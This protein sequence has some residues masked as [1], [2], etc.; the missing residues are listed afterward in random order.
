MKEIGRWTARYSVLAAGIALFLLLTNLLAFLF[1]GT[2]QRS[3]ETGRGVERIA[4]GLVRVAEGTEGI[5]ESGD[6]R[7]VPYVLTKE[8]ERIFQEEGLEWG[9][10][11]DS[12]G[13]V[14]WSEHLPEELPRKYTLNQ[15]AAFS[16]WYLEDYPVRSWEH[17]DG[18]FVAGF[19]KGSFWKYQIVMP[20]ERMD[21]VPFLLLAGFAI[22]VAAA[23]FLAFFFSLRMNRALKPVVRGLSDLAEN[24]P[25][26]LR[27]D[28]VLRELNENINRT[29]R[30]LT[31]QKEAL[32][33]RDD[34]RTN[35]IAGVSHDIRTPLSVVM[36]YASRMEEDSELPEEVRKQAGVIR[37]QSEIL[38]QLISDL[39]LT[40]KLEYEMQPVRL[41]ELPPASVVR[42]S[43]VEFLNGG[44]A[45]E[46]SIEMETEGMGAEDR[47][48]GDE[49]LL[50]RAVSNLIGNSIR[51]N[52]RGCAI[53]IRVSHRPL[54]CGIVI[55]D[56]GKGFPEAASEPGGGRKGMGLV[57]VERILKAH[58]GTAEFSNSP[59]GGS[60]AILR[61][62]WDFANGSGLR[63]HSDSD[64]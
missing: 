42:A 61:I 46:F 49:T 62:P 29:S 45:E 47:I 19:P 44:L 23:L 39:N 36:G 7:E 59:E 40:S 58:G 54:Y 5:G 14:I 64:Q 63:N 8:A 16:R 21:R 55:E 43:A 13:S 10:L 57:L 50:K 18:L 26:E 15:V 25:V 35:W 30:E 56:D 6:Q 1:W 4:E 34:A 32:R 53:K 2:G 37:S 28:G 3:A 33:Q 20:M 12:R 11:L 31:R 17:E 52:P 27:V 9:M 60:R 48:L 41:A 38:R 24:Q 22:N 51:H